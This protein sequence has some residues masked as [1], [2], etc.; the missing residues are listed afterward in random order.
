MSSR[1]LLVN[2][3]SSARVLSSTLG[4]RWCVVCHSMQPGPG[5]KNGEYT[6]V[7]SATFHGSVK[8]RFTAYMKIEL[9]RGYVLPR[10]ERESDG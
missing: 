1:P 6:V 8:D 2:A 3:L 7:P 9:Y 4:A 5:A 10:K